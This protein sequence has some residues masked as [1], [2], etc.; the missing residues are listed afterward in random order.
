MKK[1]RLT[2]THAVNAVGRSG[3]MEINGQWAGRFPGLGLASAANR[4][5]LGCARQVGAVC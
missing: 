1:G 4:F 3:M 2:T 5:S